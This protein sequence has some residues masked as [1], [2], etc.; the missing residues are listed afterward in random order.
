MS[1]PTANN[2]APPAKLGTSEISANLVQSEIRAMSVESDRIHGINLAQGVCDIDPPAAVVEAAVAAMING[3]NIYTRLDG[4]AKLRAEIARK[5]VDYNGLITDPESGILVTSGATGAFLATCMA[6]FNPGDEVLLFEPFYGYHWNT[7]LAQRLTPVTVLLDA[8]D[9][10]LDIDRLEHSITAKTRAIVVNTPCN[11]SGKVFRREELEAIARIAERHDL[12]VITDEIYEYFLCGGVKHISFASLPGMAERTITISGFSKTFSITGWR[13]GY[14]SADPKWIPA[15]GY[16][17]DVAYV[18]APA[19]LQYGA[20]AGLLQLPPGYYLDLAREY[21]QKRD[22]LVA[23]LQAADLTPSIPDGAYYILADV[24]R[25]PGA[26]AKQKARNLLAST[27]VAAVAGSAFFTGGRGENLMR[28]C[29]A[30][31]PEDL[32]EACQRLRSLG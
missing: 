16:F 14:L 32:A 19:P 27:G 10:T 8:P 24:S 4:I 13:L 18:C 23:A 7:L 1:R 26:T 25:L 30:K 20:A 29:Y 6:V 17:H 2:A 31:K 28:F 22:Q 12:F 5:L 9:W 15:I 3:R 11:P 21:E